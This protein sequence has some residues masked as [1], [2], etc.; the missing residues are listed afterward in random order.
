MRQE[1]VAVK[2]GWHKLRFMVSP[3]LAHSH[4]PC[5]RARLGGGATRIL[6]PKSNLTANSI[7]VHRM[8]TPSNDYFD[9]LF[10]NCETSAG[11]VHFRLEAVNETCL[12]RMTSLWEVSGSEPEEPI[13]EEHSTSEN[14]SRRWSDLNKRQ[15]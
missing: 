3:R 1:F 7:E 15:R 4:L 6:K 9:E 13:S 14:S 11:E 5:V 12:F 10:G 2:P 8:T